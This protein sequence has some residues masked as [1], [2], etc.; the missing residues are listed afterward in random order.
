MD[1]PS[2]GTPLPIGYTPQSLQ[3][4]YKALSAPIDQQTQANAGAAQTGAIARGLGGT[5]T[6]T[7][8]VASANYYGQLAKSQALGQLGFQM[9]GLAN[10]DALIKSQQDWQGK[11]NDLQRQYGISMEQLGA[12][13]KMNQMNTENRFGYQSGLAGLAARLG[14]MAIGGPAGGAVAGAVVDS[15]AGQQLYPGG[16]NYPAA[17][18]PMRASWNPMSGVPGWGQ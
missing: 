18:P 8:G 12:N 9:A 11:Q 7:G 4:Y 2:S 15:G 1:Y 6:E 3:D 14:G 10:Q 16:S 13:N 17:M 5:P